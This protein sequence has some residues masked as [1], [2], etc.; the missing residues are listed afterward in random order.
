[1]QRIEVNMPPEKAEAPTEAPAEEVP[2]DPPVEEPV[3]EEEAPVEEPAAEEAPAEEAP[4]EEPPVETPTEEAPAPAPS[5][6]PDI[7]DDVKRVASFG[8]AAATA[9]QRNP[10]LYKMYLQQLKTDGIRLTPEDEALLADAPAPQTPQP[11]VP[12]I[13]KYDDVLA[14]ARKMILDGKEVEASDVLAKWHSDNATRELRTSLEAVKAENKKTNEQL[15]KEKADEAHRRATVQV[16]EN[17]RSLATKFPALFIRDADPKSYTGIDSKDKEFLGKFYENVEKLGPK[18]TLEDAVKFTLA[19]MGRALPKPKPVAGQPATGKPA[20]KPA[21][22]KLT[23]MAQP[24]KKPDWNTGK[25]RVQ[26]HIQQ[27]K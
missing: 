25:Q 19:T 9:M 13:E 7:P 12:E 14:K 22:P 3:V 24:D 10:A 11:P 23:G 20:A 27:G 8:H 5:A 4:A 2:P 21:A 6:E 1:M 15:A 17:F 26:V 16:Q 18:T